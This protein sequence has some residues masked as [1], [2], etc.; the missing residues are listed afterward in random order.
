MNYTEAFLMGMQKLKEA[1]RELQPWYY[2]VAIRVIRVFK[3]W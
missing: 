1:Q 2:R 3:F